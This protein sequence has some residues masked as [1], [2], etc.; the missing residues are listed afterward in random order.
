VNSKTAYWVDNTVVITTSLVLAWCKNGS[1]HSVT[2]N[3]R[4]DIPRQQDVQ[5][6]APH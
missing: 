5:S 3:G 6:A 4:T 2:D 1:R